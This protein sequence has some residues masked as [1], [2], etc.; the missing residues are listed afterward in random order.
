MLKF[1][2]NS[3]FLQ[4]DLEVENLAEK[5]GMITYFSKMLK[6]GVFF[7]LL[8]I[9]IISV[10]GFPPVKQEDPYRIY[11]F[12]FIA[13]NFLTS[14][15]IMI[16]LMTKGRF[17]ALIDYKYT[18]AGLEKIHNCDAYINMPGMEQYKH[19]VDSVKTQGRELTNFECDEIINYW[20][21][22]V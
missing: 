5:Q 1:N 3:P 15:L 11:F 12:L 21:S 10:Y 8:G 14:F 13:W 19:Y 16:P 7:L 22:K 6:F 4:K 20:N 17:I 18:Q 9:T 2:V